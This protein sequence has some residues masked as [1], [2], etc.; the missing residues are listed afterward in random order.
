MGNVRLLLTRSINSFYAAAR[1]IL[2]K[3]LCPSARVF[4]PRPQEF[5]NGPV[6]DLFPHLEFQ[7]PESFRKVTKIRAVG[8]PGIGFALG[9]AYG[10]SKNFLFVPPSPPRI[11]T[12][13]IPSP[14]VIG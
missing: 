8:H 2:D 10:F 11:L 7:K 9:L 13:C 12:A 5:K 14:R 1:K 3:Q 6:F 4:R